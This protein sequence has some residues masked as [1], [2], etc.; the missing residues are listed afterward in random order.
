LTNFQDL[1][2]IIPYKPKS[3]AT[4]EEKRVQREGVLRQLVKDLTAQG[5]KL[6]PV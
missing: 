6:K 1:Q 3:A 5:V 2:K 4:P